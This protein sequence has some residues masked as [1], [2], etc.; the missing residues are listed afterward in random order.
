MTKILLFGGTGRTGTHLIDRALRRGFGVVALVRDPSKLAEQEGLVVR[1]GTPMNRADVETALE[2]CDAV[3][4]AL[5]NARASELPWAKPVS[6]TH[7]M[8]TAMRNAVGALQARG[9][10]RIVTL[11]ANGA[12]DSFETLFWLGRVLIRHTNLGVAYADHDRQE[13]VLRESGLDWTAVR[14]AALSNGTEAKR[15]IV[16]YG[17]QPK[18]AMTISRR[19]VA[20]FMLDVLDRSEFYQKAPT[21]SER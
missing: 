10:R 16:S 20:T 1:E 14:P 9:L 6:P 13:E 4:S 17:N 21:I 3:V 18:P 7:L 8:E 5:N 12:G 19:H 2:G 15:L 11:S